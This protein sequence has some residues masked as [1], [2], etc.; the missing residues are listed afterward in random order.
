MHADLRYP[1]GKAQDQ[2]FPPSGPYSEVALERFLY[3]IRELPGI[4]EHAV[5]NM[6]DGELDTPYRTGG[7]T[8]R[9]VV[10]HVADSH[11]NAFIRFKLALTE[12][13]PVIKPY[14]QDAWAALS[15]VTSTPVDLSLALLRGLHARWH[16]LMKNMSAADWQRTFFHPQ[17]NRAITLWSTAGMYAWHGRHH[18]AQIMQLRKK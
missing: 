9:Q 3:D 12:D 14:D 15:D 17:Q 18:T 1:I 11:M 16:E 10:H 13:N 8:V 7:W 2:P 6:D 5:L 4:L